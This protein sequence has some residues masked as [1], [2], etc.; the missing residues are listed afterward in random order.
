[1]DKT[2]HSDNRALEQLTSIDRKD[3]TASTDGQGHLRRFSEFTE[4]IDAGA[5]WRGAMPAE[6][7]RMLRQVW[8]VR[9]WLASLERVRR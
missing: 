1:M 9:G 6:R 3:F 8:L 7:Q 2:D 5:V 4:R